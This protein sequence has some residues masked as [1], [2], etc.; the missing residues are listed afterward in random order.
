MSE[1]CRPTVYGCEDMR[2]SLEDEIETVDANE[3]SSM[4]AILR[5]STKNSNGRDEMKLKGSCA[6]SPQL[7]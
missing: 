1:N 5:A 2:M 4:W 3:M 7:N 6:P